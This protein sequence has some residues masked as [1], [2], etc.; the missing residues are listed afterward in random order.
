V[1]TKKIKSFKGGGDKKKREVFFEQVELFYKIIDDKLD[2]LKEIKVS[3]T[4]SATL[5]FQGTN[6]SKDLIKETKDDSKDASLVSI[7]ETALKEKDNNLRIAKVQKDKKSNFMSRVASISKVNQETRESRIELMNNFNLIYTEFIVPY[8]QIKK[9]INLLENFNSSPNDNIYTE[10]NKAIVNLTSLE[11]KFTSISRINTLLDILK[12]EIKTKLESLEITTP[13]PNIQSAYNNFLLIITEPKLTKGPLLD[14][15]KILNNIK[16]SIFNIKEID[17]TLK[18]TLKKYLSSLLINFDIDRDNLLKI[19]SIAFKYKIKLTLK[20]NDSNYNTCEA[21]INNIIYSL[22]VSHIQTFI[23]IKRLIDISI[24]KTYQSKLLYVLYNNIKKIIIAADITDIIKLFGF[25][26]LLIETKTETETETE[27]ITDIIIKVYLNNI[28]HIEHNNIQYIKLNNTNSNFEVN[29]LEI[30]KNYNIKYNNYL[31][32]RIQTQINDTIDHLNLF[33]LILLLRHLNPDSINKHLIKLIN[34]IISD[35][36]TTTTSIV[37]D[38][39]KYN[40]I[41][42]NL[43]TEIQSQITQLIIDKIKLEKTK[44]QIINK[45]INTLLLLL[46]VF[47]PIE[48]GNQITSIISKHSQ[49]QIKNKDELYQESTLLKSKHKFY[50]DRI[51]KIFQEDLINYIKILRYTEYKKTICH[52]T[53]NESIKDLCNNNKLDEISIKE[54]Y[55]D[56]VIDITNV[57]NI[58]VKELKILEA[59][60]AP[61]SGLPK[62]GLPKSGSS[63]SGL[64]KSGSSKSGSSKSGSST[65]GL[66]KSGLPKS[67]SSKSGSSKSGSSTSGLPKSELPKYNNTIIENLII[68]LCNSEL[69]GENKD[70][71][72]ISEIPEKIPTNDFDKKNISNYITQLIK[73]NYFKIEYFKCKEQEQEQEQKQEPNLLDCILTKLQLID[74]IMH[75][76]F[77]LKKGIPFMTVIKDSPITYTYREDTIKKI[78]MD[79]DPFSRKEI[80]D[81]VKNKT[82][83]N[84][85]TLINKEISDN[86]S[87]PEIINKIKNLREQTEKRLHVLNIPSSSS[88]YDNLKKLS[89]FITMF[90]VSRHL[91][92][93]NSSSHSGGKR[94]SRHSKHS[95]HSSALKLN[96]T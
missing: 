28:I 44:T 45:N 23:D 46:Y 38:I 89:S 29:F 79:I 41:K 69:E 8:L 20:L 37:D 47:N 82:L 72:N 78:N 95:K 83:I 91:D 59:L 25:Y 10:Y 6:S 66:P 75:T 86:Y 62:S 70:T 76:P 94:H 60:E 14:V 77:D 80:V 16:Q 53:Q 58:L 1:I 55:S 19:V 35:I 93:A 51:I 33:K 2:S 31:Y 11:K 73:I 32:T 3:P 13:K 57:I 39:F 22:D 36:Q 21:Y 49:E 30:I 43:K 12:K 34:Y 63:K 5:G 74:P 64:P 9:F 26:K 68:L 84:I 50:D 42:I 92:N 96:K 24:E 54:D 18:Q 27:K 90:D 15:T 67:G 17:E 48:V 7:L 40:S 88:L 71:I 87:L 61:K 81:K 65:S 4:V 52:T 56:K 85:I